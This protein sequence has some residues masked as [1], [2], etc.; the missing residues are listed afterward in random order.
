MAAIAYLSG[1]ESATAGRMNSLFASLDAKLTTVLGGRSFILNWSDDLTGTVQV[2]RVLM[3]KA[4][5]FT[6]GTAIYA[7]RV[8]GFINLNPGGLPIARPYN[9][10]QFTSAAAAAVVNAVVDEVDLMRID[11]I[12]PANYS[13]LPE[14]PYVGF[15]DH[16]LETHG[17]TGS[18]LSALHG[19]EGKK[20][21]LFRKPR[22]GPGEVPRLHAGRNHH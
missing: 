8:P 6:S 2:P 21:L 14:S 11:N 19:I 4:F 17:R 3:G 1:S 15:F 12:G 20:Y 22:A 7:R 16:S 5:F 9:H 13:G 10:A 18:G